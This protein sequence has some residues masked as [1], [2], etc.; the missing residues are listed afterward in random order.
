MMLS[1]APAVINDTHFC[2][3]I[4]DGRLAKIYG[5][6]SPVKQIKLA[7]LL[8]ADFVDEEAAKAS[9][10]IWEPEPSIIKKLEK[11]KILSFEH[12]SRVATAYLGRNAP[13]EPKQ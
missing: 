13:K 7:D 8:P 4:A 6:E 10:D 3:K 5:S 12:L 9:F 1:P 11:D 2:L